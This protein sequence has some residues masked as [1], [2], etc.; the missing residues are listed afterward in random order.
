MFQTYVFDQ[1]VQG[2]FKHCEILG[3][4]CNDEEHQNTN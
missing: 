2:K 3:F 1:E 4:K